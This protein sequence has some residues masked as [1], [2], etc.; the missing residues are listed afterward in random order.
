MSTIQLPNATRPL[1]LNKQ[2]STFNGTIH[3]FLAHHTNRALDICTACLSLADW[4]L[5]PERLQHIGYMRL[6][7]HP[8]AFATIGNDPLDNA[9]GSLLSETPREETWADHDYKQH[10]SG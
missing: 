7:L 1:L 5:V 6:Y 4:R 3:Y 2:Q 9:S 10:L 8:T